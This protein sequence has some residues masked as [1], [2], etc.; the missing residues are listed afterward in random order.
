M[1]LVTMELTAAAMLTSVTRFHVKMEDYVS[2]SRGPLS[3]IAPTQGI[4]ESN[5]NQ[6]SMNVQLSLRSVNIALYALTL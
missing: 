6:M 3:V 2:T 4:K 1:E 5:V